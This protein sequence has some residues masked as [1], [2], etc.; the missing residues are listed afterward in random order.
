MALRMPPPEMA[1]P[2]SVSV[3]WGSRLRM[4]LRS[5]AQTRFQLT[6]TGERP[7]VTSSASEAVGAGG[8]AP[9]LPRSRK[10]EWGQVLNPQVIHRLTPTIGSRPRAV[11][12][13]RYVASMKRHVPVKLSVPRIGTRSL[14]LLCALMMDVVTSGAVWMG[15]TRRNLRSGS[16]VRP[17]DISRT[18]PMDSVGLADNEGA[19]IAPDS[20]QNATQAS[21]ERD[22]GDARPPPIRQPVDPRVEGDPGGAG[23]QPARSTRPGP[24]GCAWRAVRLS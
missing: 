11:A 7:M 13:R 2:A 23:E 3:A 6:R 22:D 16:H 8:G 19:V 24:V 9:I 4:R 21:G 17:S 18:R 10:D 1:R 14:S 15:G 5:A 12:A 20:K